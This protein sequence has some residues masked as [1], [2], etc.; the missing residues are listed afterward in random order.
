M[1]EAAPNVT[2]CELTVFA[3]FM[4]DDD[5]RSTDDSDVTKIVIPASVTILTWESFD[6]TDAIEEIT[7]EQGSQL[8]EFELCALCACRSVKSICIPATVEVIRFFSRDDTLFQFPPSLLETITFEQGSQLREI[9]SE[10]FHKCDSLRS[11]CL[12]ASVQ[13]IDG[14]TFLFSHL[15]EISVESGNPF[16][17]AN[18]PFLLDYAGVRIV[19]Y[20]GSEKEVIISSEIE[21]MGKCCFSF[22]GMST[23][24]F[25]AIS[26]LSVI[27]MDGFGYCDKLQSITIPSSVRILGESCFT[28]C[29]VLR[30]VSFESDSQLRIIGHMAFQ[31]C[32]L[33]TSIVLPSSLEI[34][35]RYCFF[36][37]GSLEAVIFPEDSKLARIEAMAFSY[38]FHLKSISLPQLLEFVGEACFFQSLYLSTLTF[39]SPSR[40]RELFDVPP[41]WEGF[42]EIPDSVEVLHLCRSGLHPVHCTVTFGRESRL[43]EVRASAGPPGLP[44][45]LITECRSFMRATPRSLK[46]IRSNLE[47]DGSG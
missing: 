28:D 32:S 41:S 15:S 35:G 24:R 46:L 9:E 11:I 14:S 43:R 1:E 12:P 47:F 40:L 17:R 39:S 42:K 10:S 30:A 6:N 4:S 36:G 34:I 38:C 31:H 26:K 5:R 27:E 23:V 29:E 33:L 7:F 13:L 22:C 20:F 37:C 25:E 2:V 44:L 21:I 18:G 19:R 16:F 3:P 45:G 8:R